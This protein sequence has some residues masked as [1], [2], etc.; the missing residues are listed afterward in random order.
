M[1]QKDDIKEAKKSGKSRF[2]QEMT[3][4]AFNAGTTFITMGAL[5]KYIKNIQN[6]TTDVK[7]KISS[8]KRRRKYITFNLL[9]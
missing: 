4:M 1:L 8:T 7:F 3:R 2:K 5:N 9:N 6:G